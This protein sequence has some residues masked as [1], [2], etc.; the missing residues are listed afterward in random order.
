M[1]RETRWSGG[2]GYLRRGTWIGGEQVYELE[3]CVFERELRDEREKVR[4]GSR[5]VLYSGCTGSRTK[6]GHF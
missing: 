3:V 6:P 5:Q 4:L 1:K 2:R